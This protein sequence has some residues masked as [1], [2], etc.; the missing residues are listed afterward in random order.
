M[1]SVTIKSLNTAILTD[2]DTGKTYEVGG[3]WHARSLNNEYK[4][5]EYYIFLNKLDVDKYPELA[6]IKTKSPKT[7]STHWKVKPIKGHD[8]DKWWKAVN[9]D[10]WERLSKPIVG[11]TETLVLGKSG[12]LDPVKMSRLDQE[13]KA[14]QLARLVQGP[15]DEESEELEEEVQ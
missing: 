2:L 5:H 12:K 14:E 3:N 7:L 13:A 10:E 1:F 9:M 8:T 11:A 15:E 4:Y 6:S